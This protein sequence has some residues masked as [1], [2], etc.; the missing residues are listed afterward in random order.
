MLHC[1]GLGNF[2]PEEL[3]LLRSGVL[4]AAARF[5]PTGAAVSLCPAQ[6]QAMTAT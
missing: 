1:F 6:A 3:C 5:T 4:Q 2:L